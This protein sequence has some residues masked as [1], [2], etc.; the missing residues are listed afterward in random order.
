MPNLLF[1]DASR[2]ALALSRVEAAKRHH[3]YVATEHLLLGLFASKAPGL[4]MLTDR[5]GV[6]RSVITGHIDAII[7]RGKD[8]HPAS[9]DMPYTSRA[10]RVLELAMQTAISMG[11]NE[12]GPEHLL[13]GV[14]AEER[15]IGAHALD[16]YG[17]NEGLVR[18]ALKDIETA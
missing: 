10:K 16:K 13:A 4:Q 1:T 7:E 11:T 2:E 18:Q 3:D 17:V 15:G 5:L 9:L 12:V 14:C 8:S 6:D